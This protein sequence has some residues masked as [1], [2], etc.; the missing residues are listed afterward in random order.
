[1]SGSLF[2]RLPWRRIGGGLE[3]IVLLSGVVYIASGWLWLL[4]IWEVLTVLY[5]SFGLALIWKGTGRSRPSKQVVRNN[6]PWAWVVPLTSSAIGSYAAVAA[7]AAH[8]EGD[9]RS[10]VV[11]GISSVGVVLSWTLLHV[12]F[13]QIYRLL[14]G[15][16]ESPAISMPGDSS[17][18][19]I[20][21][22]Y[23]SFTI[24]TAFAT[25]DARVL[26]VRA[27]R[28]VLIQSVVSFFYNAL[29]VAIAFQVL[30]G[31]VAA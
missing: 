27:R 30:Q 9:A 19:M 21:Y 1:M 5:L 31:I 14:N 15:R 20:D 24:G 3:S 13:A 25:S 7:L 22:I 6:L 12:G 28:I 26:A 11:A 4:V 2:A 23:F 8:E 16:D 17:A 10:L 29:V 18:M